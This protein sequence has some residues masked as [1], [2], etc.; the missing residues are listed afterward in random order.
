MNLHFKVLALFYEFIR[1]Y[2]K[3]LIERNTH[4]HRNIYIT[5]LK[6]L[7]IKSMALPYYYIRYTYHPFIVLGLH[8]MLL[9]VAVLPHVS[10]KYF[11]S[12]IFGLQI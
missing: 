9:F 3:L 1:S 7:L 4:F 5:N 2:H 8:K 12:T 10:Q 11:S 6:A